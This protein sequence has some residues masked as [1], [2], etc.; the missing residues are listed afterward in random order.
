MSMDSF[1]IRLLNLMQ[2]DNRQTAEQLGEQIGLSPS[3]CQR[4]LKKLREDGVIA[5]DISVIA[6]EAVGYSIMMIV[7]VTLEREQLDIVEQFKRSMRETDEVMQCY[8][9]TGEADFV[10]ILTVRD[11][12][13]YEDFTKKFF[14]DNPQVR[15]FHTIVVMDRVKFGLKIPIYRHHHTANA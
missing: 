9:V 7:K 6:P 4:R 2:T 12:N 8:Y 14:F 10:L 13:H 1:D 5:A 3:A 15:R 11:M